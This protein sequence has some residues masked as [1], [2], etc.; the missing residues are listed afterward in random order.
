MLVKPRKDL[1]IKYP[2]E[3]R[4]KDGAITVIDR[5]KISKIASGERPP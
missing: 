1:E 2:C 3:M 5:K 4:M